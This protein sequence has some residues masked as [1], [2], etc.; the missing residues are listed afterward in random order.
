MQAVRYCRALTLV[1]AIGAVRPALAAEPQVGAV[2]PVPDGVRRLMQDR[3]YAEAVAAID[4]AAQADGSPREY[5]AYL[6]GWAF[7]LA[8]QHEA[9]AAAFDDLQESFPESPWARHGRFGKAVALA[10]KGDFRGAEL[11]YRAEAE[12][13]FSGARREE[14]ARVCFDLADAFFSPPEAPEK[15]PDYEAAQ[16][17]Y[18]KAL[19]VAPECERR[20]E[21]ELRIARCHQERG[22]TAEA[23]DLFAKL[24]GER[25][26]GPLEAEARCRWGDCRF[27]EGDLKQARRIWQDLLAEHPDSTSKWI[28]RAAFRLAETWGVPQPASD[29][30]LNLG[31]AALEGAAERFPDHEWAPR[32][33]LDVAKS[34]LHRD[35]HEEAVGA[36]TRFL[37]DERYGDRDEIADARALLGRAYQLQKKYAEA[38]GAWQEYLA[39]HSS[40]A[41]SSAVQRRVIDTEYMM[42]IEE[43]QANDFDA[44]RKLWNAFLVKYPLDARNPQILFHFAEIDYEQNEWEAAIA[45][46][47]RVVSK[48]PE[49]EEAAQSQLRIA[50]TLERKLNRFD[51]ALHEYRK[52]ASGSHF[53]DAARA[54]TRL[55]AKS[56]S[57]ATDRVFRSDETPTIQVATRNV[58][59]VAVR[60]YEIDMETYFRKMHLAQ[61]VEQL[62]VSL[63]DPDV[64]F[65][66]EVP[67]YTEYQEFENAVEV[68]MPRGATSGVAVVTVAG[69]TLEATTLVI[70]SDLD[71]IVKSSR[72]EVFVFAENMRTGR[73]WPGVRLVISDG[74]QAFAE[75]T[76]GEDGVLQKTFPE[77]HSA[78][79]VRVF[80]IADGHVASNV[81][82][83]EGL[84]VA[85]GLTDKGYIYTDRPAYRAGQAVDVRGCLR[86]AVDDVYLPEEGKKVTLGVVDV[87]NRLLREE[88]VTLSRFGTFHARFVLPATSPQGEYRVLVRDEVGRSHQGSFR[89]HEYRIEPIR[90]TVDA[91]RNVYYRGEEIE[92]TIRAAFYYGAPLADHEVRYTLAGGRTY[93]ARTD[94]RGEVPFKLATRDFSE[95]QVLPMVVTLPE[96]NV[97]AARNFFLAT[98][99]FGIAV[100]SVRPVYLA[101]E[102]FEITV[103]TYDAE[104]KPVGRKLALE[105][106]ERTTVEGKVGERLVQRHEIETDRAEGIARQTLL[107][108]QGGD[109]LLRA[110]GIDR[111]DNAVSGALAVRVSGDDDEVRLRILAERHTYKVG[112]TAELKLHWRD[113]PALALVTFQGARVLDYRLVELATGAN[114]LSIPM[115]EKLAPNFE[116]S[117]A[118]MTDPRPAQGTKPD[119]PPRRFHVASSPFA[120]Q[121]ELAVAIACRRKKGAEGPVRPG[122]AL[123]VTLTTTDP[124]GKPV[125]AELSLAMVEQSLL[126]RFEW[127]VAPIAEVF[128]GEPREAAVRTTSSATFAYH[129]TTRP[130][131]PRLLSEH[132]RAE[133]ARQEEASLREAQVGMGEFGGMG[134]GFAMGPRSTGEVFSADADVPFRVERVPF[135]PDDPFA[136]DVKPSRESGEGKATPVDFDSLIELITTTVKPAGWGGK[137]SV[138]GSDERR[139]LVASQSQSQS[140]A[141]EATLPETAIEE[142]GYWNPSIVTDATGQATVTIAVPDRSTAWR[143]LAKGITIDT[144]AGEAVDDL[145]VKHDLF[146][147]LTL[148]LAF[149]DGDEAEIVASVHNG[150][151]DKGPIEVVLKTTIAGRSVEERKTIGV[152]AKGIYEVRFPTV[153]ERPDGSDGEKAQDA[154]ARVAARFELTVS[155][156]PLRNVT[157]RTVPIRPYGMPVFSAAGGTAT[158]DTTAWV[159]PPQGVPLE[160]AALEIVVGPTVEQSLLDIV[161]GPVSWCGLESAATAAGLDSTTA[162]LMAS[163]ALVDLLGTTRDAGGPQAQALD[164][165]IRAAVSLLVS[166]QNEDGGWSWTGRG[167]QSDRLAAARVAWALSLAR[168]AGYPVS[169]PTHDAAL[170]YLQDQLTRTPNDD[171]E[172]KA[173][174]LHALTVAG[175]GDFSVANRL[176]RDRPSL[177]APA[178]AYLA[179]T[180]AHVDRKALAG[181]A[182]DLLAQ[183]DWEDPAGPGPSSGNHSR[184]EVRALYALAIQAVTPQAPEAK[185][186]VDWLLAHRMGNRWAP[187]KA[188][189]PAAMALAQWFAQSRFEGERYRLA[190]FVNDVRVRDLEI[191]ASWPTQRIDVPR[192]ALREGKQRVTFQITGRGRYTYQCLLGGFVPAE[193]LQ[194]TTDAWDV[195]RTYQP[196]PLE[197]DGREIARGFGVVRGPHSRFENPLTE[198]PVGRRALVDLSVRRRVAADTPEG[199]LSYLAM[200]EPIPSGATVIESSVRG[201][202]ER[203]EV[204]PGAIIFHVGNRRSVGT[205]HYE[206]YGYLPGKYRAGPT[207]IADVYR[208]E[209]IAVASPKP[210]AVLPR[211][212]TGGDAYRLSPDELY[213]LGK[214]HFDRGDHQ[215]AAEHL[216]RLF[217]DWSLAPEAYKN[218]VRMLLDVHIELGPPGQVV[219]FFEI[220]MER[221]PD[222]QIP[223]DQCLKIAAAYHEMGEYE[224]SYLAY[225]ATV[226][227]GFTRESALAGFLDARSE[228]LRSVEVMDRLLRE[229]PPEPYAAAAAYGL[230]QRVYAKAPEA[231]GDA[232][233][234]EAR[235][236]RVDLIRRA[237]AMFDH[238]LTAYPEDP[239]ADQAA[240]ARANTLLD[241]EMYDQAA[242]AC[243]RY[244][245]RYPNSSLLDTYWYIIGYCRFAT[246][247]HEAA[248]EMCRK[249]A[250]AKRVDPATGREEDSPNKWRAVY[251][252]GQIH[253][254]LGRA[255]EAIAEYRR[256]E[257]RFEDARKSIAY[258]LRKAIA[259]PE[260]T[261]LRPGEPVAVELGFRNLAACDVKVYRIDLMKFTLLRQNLHDIA[262]INLAGI[263][264]LH[265]AAVELGDGRDYR[266]RT[267]QLDLPLADEGAYLVVCR[268]EDLHASGLVLITPLALEVETDAAAG[269][270]RATV[271]DA[272]A[273]RFVSHVEVKVIGAGNVDFVTGST[274]LR[275]VFV[276]DG[277]RGAPTVIARAGPGRY[278]FYRDTAGPPSPEAFEAPRYAAPTPPAQAPIASAE[279][280]RATALRSPGVAEN[281]RRIEAALNAPTALDFI[282]TP[283]VD[284]V[285][286]LE[287]LHGI[288]I[289]INRRALDDVGIPTDVPVTRKLHGISLRSALK[290]MLDEFDLTFLIESEVL[291]IT[292]PE[293]AETRLETVAYP[294]SD[295]GFRDKSGQEWIDYDTLITTITTTIEPT[296]WDDVGGAGSISPM[297]VGGKHFLVL[298]QTQDVHREVTALLENMRRLAGIEPG[299][300]L[301]VREIPEWVGPG[302]APGP[303]GGFG[304]FGAGMGGMGGMGGGMFP[305]D[306]AP[307]APGAQ[308]QAD[309]LKGLHDANKQLQG[310]Q[311][312]KLKRM[313]EEGGAMGGMGAG[314]F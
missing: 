46:W 184:A 294:V 33:R 224:R 71:V 100:R 157:R 214:H 18:E 30:D 178:L 259:L 167:D 279:K 7:H 45:A 27:A 98:Q 223:F 42:G 284:V 92:G 25:P 120:V 44:A 254:S 192:L 282:E 89:V 310:Q 155:A 49:S 126:D 187:D 289:E 227:T 309:L 159:E 133:I 196:A 174:L 95:S 34:Y 147:E 314:F 84:G 257:D 281:R 158:T 253:H 143:L 74:K 54:I 2:P 103:K 140:V 90:L 183:R 229:Y 268:G 207:V 149:T 300:E 69:K 39:Q 38:L 290:L 256:V 307:G 193:R 165:R 141:D 182:L 217:D 119:K 23:A 225:R 188:T 186:Q 201:A 216:T 109:Y 43:F 145:T 28:A 121:R 278:A 251:I 161:R 204:G 228:F 124:Q 218:T 118:V 180:L 144:L 244:A 248:L 236:N 139:S 280:Y 234:R 306:A 56:L 77:L 170:A 148:P 82:G 59:A 286:F 24:A 36:L 295:F 1:L 66:L 164:G 60:V 271:K 135:A 128:R 163:L 245:E 64:T 55:T 70:R 191:D 200:T 75:A 152:E 123:E 138:A 176:H 243:N 219:R 240:F 85:R 80:A 83:L 61:G 292:T 86:R 132:E 215:A 146:G 272:T 150:A 117:V 78:D 232:R 291:L 53:A 231:A 136:P 208:P 301:P 171:Y 16:A 29:E 48:Y 21:V 185:E 246:G 122:E 275:G 203:F 199:R 50:A 8:G 99:G 267:H 51:E 173:V 32:A 67:G 112:D 106:L 210:L 57:V 237:S 116:L 73:P 107:L 303:F 156:G 255:A 252:L 108:E 205:I 212:A 31:V 263:R 35:R 62:D 221:W 213:A 154:S 115:A 308:G 15:Q 239:A 179:L 68:P 270:V 265:E 110:E 202:F 10:R 264:S 162:D 298:S 142:T 9:A 72:D 304:G 102:S 13:L 262:R 94:E 11:I 96:R 297:E 76:T 17:F 87:R 285:E 79:D 242:A 166:S 277:I 206:L 287:K 153:L 52:V 302:Y 3:N 65:E 247:Q 88:E 91:P 111:F 47:R 127:P 260:V 235:L 195:R 220:V 168:S 296:A 230:A 26:G 175:R 293:E 258:F 222:E 269:Q 266:D 160:G 137:Q 14:L 114:A 305:P 241:L 177:S 22:A 129:P 190:V 63:I 12:Y 311:V 273:D 211:G 104:G 181:D 93:A 312:D 209:Q 261:T 130:V 131:N 226:E 58:E 6:K 197:V 274:D 37:A 40:H 4:E 20:T 198:L 81:V 134:G 189:G 250:E 238:F 97:E 5:L 299:G 169:G 151:V 41:S 101:G 19:E 233:L 125:V 313:Y 172:G 283:L 105:V 249:V 113:E 194:S 276:A 288:P